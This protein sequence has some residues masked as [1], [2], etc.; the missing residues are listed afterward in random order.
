[1]QRILRANFSQKPSNCKHNMVLSIEDKGIR[2]QMCGVQNVVV[3]DPNIDGCRSMAKECALFEPHSTK[4]EIREEFNQALEEASF[5]EIMTEFPDVGTL[6]WVLD[7]PT[8]N[9]LGQEDPS[10]ASKES[11][12]VEVDL[13]DLKQAIRDTQAITRS[14]IEILEGELSIHTKPFPFDTDESED[15]TE[16]IIFPENRISA[17]MKASSA[18]VLALIFI[19]MVCWLAPVTSLLQGVSL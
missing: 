9:Q 8:L 5:E 15:L 4:E 18:I 7:D 19:S 13:P 3:C 6:M 17:A 16:A 10:E 1:M 2:L 12:E 14:V 11:V